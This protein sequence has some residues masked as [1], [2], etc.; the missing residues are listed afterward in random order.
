MAN[1]IARL[2]VAVEPGENQ[3]DLDHETI[4][5][6]S[7]TLFIHHFPSIDNFINCF[8]IFFFLHFFFSSSSHT[9]RADRK[10]SNDSKSRS[11]PYYSLL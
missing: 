6:T 8:L 11:I 7:S 5:K 10:N 4:N 3:Q 9:L 2:C 1:I